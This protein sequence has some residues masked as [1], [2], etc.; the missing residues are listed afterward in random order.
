VSTAKAALF[1]GHDHPLTLEEVVIPVLNSGECLVEIS[2]CSLCRSDLHTFSGNRIEPT[3]TILGHEIV[4]RLVECN[5]PF[6]AGLSYGDRV[7]WGIAASCGTCFYC[8]R[9]FPQKCELLFKYGHMRVTPSRALSGGLASHIVLRAG[10]I[11]RKVPE[12]ISDEIASLANCSTATAAAA[13]RTVETF[14]G[15]TVVVFGAG[16]L[17]LSAIAMLHERECKVFVMDPF[18][19][20]RERARLFGATAVFSDLQEMKSRVLEQTSGRGADAALE[21]SGIRSSAE[22]TFSLVRIGGTVVWAGTAS[23]VGDVPIDPEQ[24]V[25]RLITLRGMHN[26]APEDLETALGFLERN[27]T[28]YPFSALFGKSFPLEHVSE[29]FKAAND[30][31]GKRITIRP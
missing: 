15:D 28:R 23:P 20:A 7:T 10:T 29:A 25:R 31:G 14:S 12:A 6:P 4:G 3:P 5:G 21:L 22:S 8:R 17:G 11:I 27:H 9:G 18:A 16:V 13:I 24:V 26:Y 19:S 30:S 2:C 1:Y